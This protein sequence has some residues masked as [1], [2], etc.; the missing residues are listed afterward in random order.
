MILW[1]LLCGSLL[2]YS[3]SDY[4][5][6][7]ELKYRIGKVY[8]VEKHYKNGK[9]DSVYRKWDAQGNKVT[10]GYYAAGKRQGKWTEW[11]SRTY[12]HDYVI[13]TYK[14]GIR[15]KMYHYCATAIDSLLKSSEAFY[16]Y[17]DEK[18]YTE[19]VIVW[20]SEIKKKSE[21]KIW[22]IKNDLWDSW[23]TRRWDKGIP[24]A[25]EEKKALYDKNG[26]NLGLYKHGHWKLWNEDGTLQKETWYNLGKKLREKRY[27]KGKL[28]EDK[29][30]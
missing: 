4:M 14:Q 15:K 27:E 6:Q 24:W 13:I 17:Q 16:T 10:E 30:Y 9:L 11:L 8:K 19:Q 29:R 18:N 25:I 23:K 26:K 22:V 28:V 2:A 5:L 12:N 1:G 20:D 21:E 7:D 3:Q